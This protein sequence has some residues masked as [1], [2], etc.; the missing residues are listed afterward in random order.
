VGASAASDGEDEEEEEE[1]EEDGEERHAGRARARCTVQAWCAEE[2]AVL[3][4]LV[5]EQAAAS[6]GGAASGPLAAPRWAA[7]A[8]RMPGRR[9]G[10]QCR[11]RY[12]NHLAP[13][14]SRGEWNDLEERALAE[15]YLLLGTKW[16]ALAR[17]LPG[18]TE[19]MVRAPLRAR[20]CVRSRS[21]APACCLACAASAAARWRCRCCV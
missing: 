9:K 16:A 3:S 2:D 19:N 5:D 6:G 20:V 7:I 17:M 21:C 4:R 13:N 11:D 10:K 12:V 15:G 18:R 8:A 1:E 14:I